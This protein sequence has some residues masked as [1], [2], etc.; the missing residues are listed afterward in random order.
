MIT[1]HTDLRARQNYDYNS[2]SWLHSPALMACITGQAG[3]A[4]R[5]IRPSA[6]AHGRRHG[7]RA[8]C[9]QAEGPGHSAGALLV[10]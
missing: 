10:A 8:G 1:S 5:V 4:A 7:V 9:G 6:T 3:Q 2:R